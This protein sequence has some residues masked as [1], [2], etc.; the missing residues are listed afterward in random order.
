M[1]RYVLDFELNVFDAYAPDKRG[2]VRDITEK[3]LGVTGIDVSPGEFR[4]LVVAPDEFLEIQPFML[5]AECRWCEALELSGVCAAG[6]KI[7]HVSEENRE[8]LRK[9]IRLLTF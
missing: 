1:D 9:L 4:T 6:F 3:G 8:S 5:K 2:T 7:V